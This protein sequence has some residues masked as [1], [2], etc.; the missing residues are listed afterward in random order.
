[1]RLYV[2]ELLSD[3]CHSIM[4]IQRSRLTRVSR[5]LWGQLEGPLMGIATILPQ[6]LD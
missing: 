3:A 2:V 5:D 4:S 6:L 1:M